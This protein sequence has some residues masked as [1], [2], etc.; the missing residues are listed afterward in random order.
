LVFRD[1]GFAVFN[2]HQAVP[3]VVGEVEDALTP[4]LS[5]RERENA[6]APGGSPGKWV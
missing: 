6:G 2:P 4:A 5:R 1:K 3:G